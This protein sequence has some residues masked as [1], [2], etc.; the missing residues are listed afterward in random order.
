MRY[1]HN[2][3]FRVNTRCKTICTTV[4]LTVSFFLALYKGLLK[5]VGCYN[6]L[7]TIVFVLISYCRSVLQST[8]QIQQILCVNNQHNGVLVPKL[9]CEYTSTMVSRRTK[10]C[11]NNLQTIVFYH[12]FV[13]CNGKESWFFVL[14]LLCD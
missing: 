5:Y 6:V 1:L 3:F 4:L 2:L 14:K 11:V 7:Q 10:S 8:L 9:L 12:A 13:V